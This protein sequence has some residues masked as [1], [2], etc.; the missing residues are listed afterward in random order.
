MFIPDEIDDPFSTPADKQI[1]AVDICERLQV[2]L[3]GRMR[4]DENEI[5]A[6]AE[7]IYDRLTTYTPLR[8]N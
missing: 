7:W 2:R 6:E 8:I 3:K 5:N 1:E 4:P